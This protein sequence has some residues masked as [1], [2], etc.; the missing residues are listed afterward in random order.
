MLPTPM[1]QMKPMQGEAP[2]AAAPRPK[3]AAMMPKLNAALAAQRAGQTPQMKLKGAAGGQLPGQSVLGG[4]RLLPQRQVG[5]V[6]ANAARGMAEMQAR[7]QQMQPP[8]DDPNVVPEVERTMGPPP[9]MA[10][11]MAR[12]GMGNGEIGPQGLGDPRM[13]QM[14]QM[15][16]RRMMEQMMQQQQGR[17][18]PQNMG[19]IQSLV[20]P[21]MGE[22][23]PPG[24]G[25]GQE[26]VGSMG[27]DPRIAQARAMQGG[28]RG[29]SPF[30]GGG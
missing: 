26:Q 1:K 18:M 12:P 2:R 17:P 22:F 7:Q 30:G 9:M 4:A 16:K 25:M 5:S 20:P 14:Q 23:Q 27:V 21:G 11:R 29:F 8:M 6:R 15:Q 19:D 10:D 13:Q 24:M 28:F 3:K